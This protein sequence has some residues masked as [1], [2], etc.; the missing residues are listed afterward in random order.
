MPVTP[1][2]PLIVESKVIAEK[3]ERHESSPF[4]QKYAGDKSESVKTLESKEISLFLRLLYLGHIQGW[5]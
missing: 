3:N 5:P 1:E 4:T 2:E